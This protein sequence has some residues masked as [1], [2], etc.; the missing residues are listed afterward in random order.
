[1]AT[2]M[3]LE[4]LSGPGAIG[5]APDLTGTALGGADMPHRTCSLD[6][7]ERKHEAHGWCKMHLKR[8]QLHGDPGHVTRPSPEERFWA[9][10]DKDGPLPTWAPFLG[11]CWLWTAS[12]TGPGYGKFYVDG[13]LTPSHRWSYEQMV[14]PIPAGLVLDHL[15]RVRR[16]CNPAHL[17]PVTHRENLMRGA[18]FV[19]ENALKTA[20]PK[21]HPLTGRNVVYWRGHRKCRECD[22]ARRRVLRGAGG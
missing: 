8:W 2:T 21:G 6:G 12:V 19:E 5:V 17:E 4:N 18:S 20:C 16:C 10:V 7:C 13:R 14:G 22:N 9:K 15:C 3:G 11:P 1:M